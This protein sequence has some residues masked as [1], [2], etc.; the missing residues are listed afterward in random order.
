MSME[1]Q[2]EGGEDEQPQDSAYHIHK[3]IFSFYYF[4]AGHS[5]F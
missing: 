3:W 1:A 4:F 5:V 2:E